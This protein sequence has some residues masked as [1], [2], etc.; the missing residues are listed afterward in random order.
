MALNDQ[1]YASLFHPD[2]GIPTDVTFK[3]NST[4]F[5][6]Q[7]KKIN[8]VDV[9]Y[10]KVKGLACL[11]ETY[12]LPSV[13]IIKIWNEE[14]T[15]NGCLSVNFLAVTKKFEDLSFVCTHVQIIDHENNKEHY[16]RAHKLL[17]AMVSPV[18]KVSSHFCLHR[19]EVGRF[20][21]HFWSNLT[22]SLFK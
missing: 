13:R 7:S 6:R 14:Q 17:L 3:V 20:L 21:R 15:V 1:N 12:R 22:R 16:E 11:L 10:L 5:S 9:S 8:D 18:F 19:S 4:G 2:C